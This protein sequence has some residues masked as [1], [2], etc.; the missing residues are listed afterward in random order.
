M[1]Q[2]LRNEIIE[3]EKAGSD[4]LRS[5]LIFTG[6]LAAVALGFSGGGSTTQFPAP[7]VLCGIPLVCVYVDLL[8][9]HLWLR[10]LV[11]GRYLRD[12]QKREHADKE[13]P[14]YEEYANKDK[15]RKVLNL[16]EWTLYWS[17]I[18][19][20]G[21]VIM[22]G[23]VLTL[24]NWDRGTGWLGWLGFLPYLFFGVLGV[25][26]SIVTRGAYHSRKKI[27]DDPSLLR[28]GVAG[29]PR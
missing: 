19:F 13:V 5:K 6:T 17:T 29:N 3:S 27:L 24:L 8:C 22:I 10:I 2:E 15:V 20:S 9:T 11:I 18:I 1:A 25:V 12:Q 28:R 14:S 26:L 23:A 7:L 4:L 16:E 21:G